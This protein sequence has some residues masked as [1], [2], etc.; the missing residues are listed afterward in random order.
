MIDIAVWPGTGRT[1]IWRWR[2]RDMKSETDALAGAAER[3][4]LG[5]FRVNAEG[6]I[7]EMNPVL[8]AWVRPGIGGGRLSIQKNRT[9]RHLSA[10]LPEASR[11]ILGTRLNRTVMRTRLLGGS[12]APR[13]VSLLFAPLRVEGGG[14]DEAIGLVAPIAAADAEQ[15]AL[16][17]APDTGID[18]ENFFGAQDAMHTVRLFE[19]APIGVA[20]L[21]QEGRIL[22][23]NGAAQRLLDGAADLGDNL[24]DAIAL[25]DRDEAV[26]RLT[27]VIANGA[28]DGPSFE[29]TLGKAA[30]TVE[31]SVVAQFYFSRLETKTGPLLLTYMVDASVERALEERFRQTQRLNAVGQLAGGVAHDFNNLLTVISG[32]SEVLLMRH[33]A[34]GDPDYA[35]LSAISQNAQRAANLV[36]QLLAYSRKQQLRPD[37]VNLT[38]TLS[39]TSHMLDRLIGE[40]VTLHPELAEDLWPCRVDATQFEQVITNLVVN[41]R[42]AITEADRPQGQILL[43]T[44]NQCFDSA[45]PSPNSLVPPG[46]YV[47][48]EVIDNGTGIPADKLAKIFDPFY[49]TKE[50][51]KGTGLG[52][53]TVYGIVKQ[54]G[55]FIFADSTTGQGTAF[56]IYL[57]RYQGSGEPVAPASPGRDLSS[58]LSAGVSATLAQ[59]KSEENTGP[60]PASN[61]KRI[62]LVEDEDPVRQMTAKVLRANGYDVL[63]AGDGEE[64]LEILQDSNEIVD[65]MLSD[66][67]MPNIDGPTL[68]RTVRDI[69]PNLRTVFMSGYPRDA[70]DSKF[71]EDQ[72]QEGP[73]QQL[74]GFIQK[75]FKLAEL[76]A[77]VRRQ[78]SE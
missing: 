16:P 77:V 57:P 68:A 54:S 76:T 32:C 19:E 71:G 24:I 38:D 20:V 37:I 10:I 15:S 59:E 1:V 61:T 7:L 31:E 51:G 35:E 55:G 34:E 25:D 74:T 49:T 14:P 52:L 12:S 9:V 67:I 40:K 5:W 64:A 48:I 13:N 21:S 36:R 53:S 75:P 69:R 50:V 66:V 6:D 58:L 56:R 44:K 42:D 22:R 3:A 78:L 28:P 17:I 30:S 33:S 41:A 73:D 70:F 47:S 29:A 72:L 60:A 27:A 2:L 43:R 11:K 23:L 39:E 63:E 4:G 65:L 45:A 26:R 46:D 18:A 62:L 8:Q